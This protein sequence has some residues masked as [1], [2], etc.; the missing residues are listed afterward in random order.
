MTSAPPRTIEPAEASGYK[1][2]LVEAEPPA[3][4]DSRLVCARTLADRFDAVLVGVGA[5]A[6][7]TSMRLDPFNDTLPFWN[8]EIRAD[9]AAAKENFHRLA[10]SRRTEW[11]EQRVRPGQAM[12]HAARSADLIV[13]GGMEQ[14][15]RLAGRAADI[16]ELAIRTGR[17]VLVAPVGCTSCVAERIVIAWKDT[18]EA[19]RAAWDAMPFLVGAAEVLVLAICEDDDLVD[20]LESAA[21]VALSLS[22]HGVAAHGDAQKKDDCGVAGTLT[23]RANAMGAD[24]VVAG[25]YGHSR[26]GEWTFGGVTRDMLTHPRHFM[27]LSH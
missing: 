14:S 9:L 1:T 17:P 24:L 21:E 2:I 27:L 8:E 10:G 18:R 7:P 5:E 4:A 6:P 26:F 12:Y 3:L 16:G 13:A 11:R 23:K 20:A 19:R 15:E 22:R 25:A